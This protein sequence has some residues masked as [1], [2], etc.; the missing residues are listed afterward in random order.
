MLDLKYD[1]ASLNAFEMFM[2]LWIKKG[3][4]RLRVG[5]CKSRDILQPSLI[6]DT[7]FLRIVCYLEY[8]PPL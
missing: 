7:V 4:N 3:C 2:I 6:M 1:V 5:H 8:L